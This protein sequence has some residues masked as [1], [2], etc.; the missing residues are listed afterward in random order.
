VELASAGGLD[1]LAFE[2]LA[3]RT[4]ALAQTERLENPEAGFDPLL[5]LR[6]EAVLS[7]C[8]D[9]GIKIITNMGA[10]NP[11]GAARKVVEVARRKGLTGLKVATVTGDDVLDMVRRENVEL[12]ERVA[13]VEDLGDSIISA[14]A[15][16]GV[17]P[18]VDALRHG[19]DVV[20]TG[21]VG[22]PALFLAPMVHEFGWALDD[23]DRL[24]A[25]TVVGHLLECAG[26]L[27]GGYF[28]DPG[29]KDVPNLARLG[30]PI[31]EVAEDGTAT[32]SK[33][34]GS[35]GCITIATCKEQLL[36]EILDPAAYPQPDVTSDF[37]QV[38]F[39][40][41]GLDRVAISGA[42]GR[43]RPKTLKVSIGFR[44]GYIGEGQISYAGPGAQARGELALAV[45]RE[46]LQII[47]AATSD[48]RFELIGVNA[49]T[50]CAP[51]ESCTLAEVR[52]RVAGRAVTRQEAEL[53]GREVESLYTNG[54]AG[55]GGAWKLARPVTAI[56]SALIPRELVVP[57]FEL[58]VV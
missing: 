32:F 17:S 43:P 9:Q 55:G 30:F 49:V 4:I 10:A 29:F 14:N 48:L 54:P 22:D 33:V 45:V 8:V 46:R 21:R 41:A 51:T 7:A 31:A 38:R 23:W 42:R 37:S 27:T 11:S 26:Q 25:G 13:R 40:Q 47:G 18:I 35:G 3:E 20:V 5:A 57:R 28:A 19:A 36:Y 50:S 52:V 15:Y 16:V 56:V 1:Y 58:E 39:S 12:L 53:I 44:D 2:C 34:E 6:M 24:A